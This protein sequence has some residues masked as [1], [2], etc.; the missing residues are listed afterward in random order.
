MSNLYHTLG[1]TSSA[2]QA[3][4]KAAYRLLIKKYHPDLNPGNDYFEE[5]IKDINRAYDILS[6][7]N[8]RANY[9]Y[10]LFKKDA[11]ETDE[12]SPTPTTTSSSFE[13]TYTYVPNE[14]NENYGQALNRYNRRMKILA[15]VFVV[16]VLSATIW[17][18][19]R[20]Y[21]LEQN[22]KEETRIYTTYVGIHPETGDTVWDQ[23]TVIG[24][25]ELL[26]NYLLMQDIQYKDSFNYYVPVNEMNPAIAKEWLIRHLQSSLCRADSVATI[27][28]IS[29]KYQFSN[30]DFRF[31]KDSLL[32]K[33]VINDTIED[34][35]A[36][37]LSNFSSLQ[38]INGHYFLTMDKKA[39]CV[40]D[41]IQKKK[42][43]TDRFYFDALENNKPGYHRKT[44]EVM[45]YLKKFS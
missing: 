17:A 23:R 24:S 40:Y 7:E 16:G 5:R 15:L 33:Y 44:E 28:G 32:M 19:I 3:E 12:P 45:F 25:P 9:D 29:K 30:F 31:S 42:V 38:K 39:I 27:K 43:W 6:N 4:I 26:N 35:V 36:V 20:S 21:R 13:S 2:T 10:L 34:N 8:L 41:F 37:P 11:I 18:L 1:V 22:Q 14:N